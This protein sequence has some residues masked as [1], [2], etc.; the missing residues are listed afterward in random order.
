MKPNYPAKYFLS[1]RY[2]HVHK[3]PEIGQIIQSYADLMGILF[4][5]L[6]VNANLH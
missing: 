4:Q 1:V 5:E 2:R 6:I 3:Y